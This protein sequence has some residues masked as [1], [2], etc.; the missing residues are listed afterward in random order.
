M[1]MDSYSISSQA[2]DSVNRGMSC[3][4]QLMPI[5]RQNDWYS[6]SFYR[7]AKNLEA[8]VIL[9]KNGD[10]SYQVLTLLRAQLENY[11]DLVNFAEYGPIYG[12]YLAYLA[13]QSN[14]SQ[15]DVKKVESAIKV[16]YLA[17]TTRYFLL[18]NKASEFR[19]HVFQYKYDPYSVP[20]IN[21]DLT[22]WT[23][24]KHLSRFVHS[25]PG[26]PHHYIQMVFASEYFMA[27]EILHSL[28]LYFGLKRDSFQSQ[29]E[30]IL[31]SYHAIIVQA[32]MTTSISAAALPA[33][34]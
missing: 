7:W 28:Y 9:M 5:E 24:D 20:A 32:G 21:F 19:Q 27:Y 25:N 23:L 13:N 1:N 30:I 22:V 12:G 10:F 15:G 26:N 33:L 18:K 17:R 31:N 4:W 29:M 34:T 2:L 6:W 8:I 16:D 11:A 3:C 14:L